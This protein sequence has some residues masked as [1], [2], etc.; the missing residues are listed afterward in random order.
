MCVCV[1]VHSIFD[2]LVSVCLMLNLLDTDRLRM[3]IAYILSCLMF[4]LHNRNGFSTSQSL[5]PV[6]ASLFLS[7]GEKT[8]HCE[9]PEDLDD[10][11]IDEGPMEVSA[12]QI[13]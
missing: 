8:V 13:T 5:P 9:A 10:L 2:V 6:P 11:A 3:V 7:L 4:F 12:E 1:C